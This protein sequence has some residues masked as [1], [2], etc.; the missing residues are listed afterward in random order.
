MDQ[1]T[2]EEQ[3][4]TVVTS[5]LYQM[6]NRFNELMAQ[7]VADNTR[8]INQQLLEYGNRIDTTIETLIANANIATDKVNKF[9]GRADSLENQ[10]KDLEKTKVHLEG[11]ITTHN[12]ISIVLG[13]GMTLI[14]AY[15]FWKK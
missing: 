14:S 12:Y 11:Q 13:V 10:I 15:L 2:N 5:H 3:Y 8:K 7:Q 4:Q 1:I 9:N 6:T